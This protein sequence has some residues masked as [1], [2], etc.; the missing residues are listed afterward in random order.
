M[1]HTR[2]R[3]HKLLSAAILGGAAAATLGAVAGA[4][5]HTESTSS[6]LPQQP[7]ACDPAD[8]R[9][10]AAAEDPVENIATISVTRVNSPDPAPDCVI[11]RTPTVS[12]GVLDGVARAVPPTE[13]APYAL[14]PG[15]TA[16]AA[17]RTAPGM[18]VEGV[19][20][21]QYISVAAVPDQEAY[22]VFAEELDMADPGIYVYDPITTW[23]QPNRSEAVDQIRQPW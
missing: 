20:V 4:S 5:A 10:S 19:E 11:D 7:S 13:S 8:L 22:A 15:E 6:P 16:H 2:N 3:R 1:K 17:V 21:V 23:W 18:G 12:F 9:M 14:S